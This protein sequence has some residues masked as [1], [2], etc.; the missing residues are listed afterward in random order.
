MNNGTPA[1]AKSFWWQEVQSAIKLGY[2]L[3]L[4]NLAQIA[5]LATNTIYFGHLGKAELA[6]GAL[7]A[8][9]YQVAMIFSLG[10][11]S[12]TVPM[13]AN[14]LGKRRSNIRLVRRIIRHGFLSAVLITLPF[15][16]LL[17]KADQLLIFLGQNPST[18]TRALP[19][20]HSLQWGLLPYL[21]Y[22]VL[23]SFLAALE[24]P[25]WTLLVAG[26]A[27]VFN[28]C[29]G[30]ILIFGAFGLPGLGL[31]GGG[32]SASITS[33]FMFLGM[34]AITY[35]HKQFRRYFIL[36][37]WWR[38]DWPMLKDLW[39]LGIPIAI[40]FTLET[41]VFYA[42]VIM[43][44]LIGE[45]ALAAH[46]IAMQICTVTY[47]IPLGFSQVATIRVGLSYG[48]AR[49]QQAVRAGWV[50][51]LLGAGFMG[52]A[53]ICMW[54][55]P[56]QLI[57]LFITADNPESLAVMQLTAQ[58]LFLAAFFQ[59]ADGA[60]AVASGML[61]GLYDTRVPMLLALLGYW[62]LG[63][64]I[65]AFLAFVLQLEGAGIWMGFI[66]GLS[67]VALLLTL[68]WHR[69]ATKLLLRAA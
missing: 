58:F 56:Y 53:A 14:V 5:I 28:A 8:S 38:Y 10:L 51:Y 63:V 66:A 23:R 7:A 11:V 57:G 39:L 54:A 18:V 9:L 46:A 62:I 1:A 17:W 48:R 67:V 47:M 24:Q 55:F 42:G 45:T 64:P 44:G 3:I 20:M 43:M 30:G 36:G 12:A 27:I 25:L 2:P 16:L 49:L 50:S 33:L 26:L 19:Y 29:L 22:I 52:I 41:L 68:R 13:L 31:Q 15:W 40:T 32:I 65:G 60:Q 4:T 61:R 35:R 37:N 59:I 34:L 69:F 6:A 21:F